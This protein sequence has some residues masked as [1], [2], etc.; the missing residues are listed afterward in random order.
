MTKDAVIGCASVDPSPRELRLKTVDGSTR[1]ILWSAI[2]VAGM[3]DRL[4]GRVTILG[5]TDKTARFAATH[6]PV[7]IVYAHGG[8][9]QLMIEKSGASRDAIL[10]SIAEQLGD[11]WSG[12]NLQ[13]SDVTGTML[14]PPKVEFPRTVTLALALVAVAFFAAI[15]I[16]FFVHGAK[17][18]A[19]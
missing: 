16:L 3:G 2:R 18:T 6:D 1:A 12:D 15:A 5:I 19:P 10:W 9:A 11:R 7:W 13:E 4:I 14:I 8:L 17:P